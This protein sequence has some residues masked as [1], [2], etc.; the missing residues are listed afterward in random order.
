MKSRKTHITKEEI[1]L[2]KYVKDRLQRIDAGNKKGY[3][4]H[5]L[6]IQETFFN[7][8]TN[9]KKF[10]DIVNEVEY[11]DLT[12]KINDIPNTQSYE[13]VCKECSSGVN[14]TLLKNLVPTADRMGLINLE[15][16]GRENIGFTLSEIGKRFTRLDQLSID[17]QDREIC[18]LCDTLAK[19]LFNSKKIET[20]F[21]FI[22]L[23]QSFLNEYEFT[24]LDFNE[25]FILIDDVIDIN[26]KKDLIFEYRRLTNTPI[27]KLKYENLI[28]NIF[29]EYN[30]TKKTK[31]EKRDFGNIK[32]QI[33]RIMEKLNLMILFTYDPQRSILT[34]KKNFG[35]IK[36]SRYRSGSDIREAKINHKIQID[37]LDGHHIIPHDFITSPFGKDR[38]LIENWK[39]IIFVDKN[40][41]SKF[42]NKNNHYLLLSQDDN[43]IIFT[44]IHNN[45]DKVIIEKSKFNGNLELLNE[46]IFHNKIVLKLLTEI[47]LIKG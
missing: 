20:G 4:G 17:E 14:Y 33:S 31:L 8:P 18:L 12:N 39:N 7:N 1:N 34:M 42:P 43:S 21:D 45:S 32:N 9:I 38:E 47:K 44:S 35:C 2:V 26:T 3:R 36:G 46:M 41:H 22:E 40:T 10:V 15:K 27:K 13:I 6:V 5:T 28:L 23:I 25:I 37:G 11:V 29:N 16:K 19:N 24:S 30:N